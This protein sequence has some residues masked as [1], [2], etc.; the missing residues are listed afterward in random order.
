M[1]DLVHS[2]FASIPG[3]YEADGATMLERAAR[4][5]AL[6]DGVLP[7]CD[8]WVD[9]FPI[10]RA[11]LMAVRGDQIELNEGMG[12]VYRAG[13]EAMFAAKFKDEYPMMS[14]GWEAMIDAILADGEGR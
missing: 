9:Y 11:V 13:F 10:A 6:A 2:G 5:A 1:T 12:D 7:E 4:A 8:S 3:G 14:C